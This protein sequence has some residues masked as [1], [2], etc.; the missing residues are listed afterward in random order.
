[1]PRLLGVDVRANCSREVSIHS[2]EHS[3]IENQTVQ[4]ENFTMLLNTSLSVLSLS[5]NIHRFI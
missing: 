4:E 1:M 5:P 2:G 3:Q